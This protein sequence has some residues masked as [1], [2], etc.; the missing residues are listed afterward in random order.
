MPQTIP[1]LARALAI[2]IATGL[3]LSASALCMASG[4]GCGDDGGSRFLKPTRI[5]EPEFKIGDVLPDDYQMLMNTRYYGL[6]A[7]RDGWVYFKVEHWLYRV[8]LTS[9]RI[10]EDATYEANNNF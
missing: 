10:L 7:P 4:D 2:A 8:D 1:L 9:R 6:P 3:P 5:S